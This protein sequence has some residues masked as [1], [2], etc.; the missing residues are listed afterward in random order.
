MLQPQ[1]LCYSLPWG[2]VAL[3]CEPPPPGC[4]PK[5]HIPHQGC[6]FCQLLG[7]PPWLFPTLYNLLY[8]P[9][10]WFVSLTCISMRLGEQLWVGSSHR[11]AGRDRE[12]CVCLS[13]ISGSHT[14]LPEWPP[15]GP[16]PPHN[17]SSLRASL[18]TAFPPLPSP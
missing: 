15:R 18:T 4:L 13:A 2:N 8:K 17:A 9:G 1:D 10:R 14:G 7:L 6:S 3:G 5:G 16:P 12:V 11:R